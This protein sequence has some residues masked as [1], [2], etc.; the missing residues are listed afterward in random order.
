MIDALGVDGWPVIGRRGSLVFRIPFSSTSVA[1]KCPR[2]G[3]LQPRPSD[4]IIDVL[5]SLQWLRS[6]DR[7][8]LKVPC[9]CTKPLHGSALTCPS[10]LVRVADLPGR[11]SN[12]M[13][14][15]SVKLSTVGDRTFPVA[16]HTT[17]HSLPDNVTSLSRCRLFISV[18]K[19]FCSRS[20]FLTSSWTIILTPLLTS[21]DPEAI[22]ITWT[23]L[24]IFYWLSGWLIWYTTVNTPPR[25]LVTV[26]T[27]QAT[28]HGPVYWRHIVWYA[29]TPASKKWDPL[30]ICQKWTILTIFGTQNPEEIW[31]MWFWICPPHLK[32]IDTVPWEIRKS[33][34]CM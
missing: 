17:C 14:V 18:Q 5:V 32:N 4:H 7:V 16:G 2:T 27:Q 29:T 24:K 34:C 28:H 22:Y 26:P 31:H 6:P 15:P 30:Y 23:T 8:Q 12:R 11:R 13:T 33:N 20:H 3:Y 1:H 25:F 21:V 19:P 10:Q 9:P